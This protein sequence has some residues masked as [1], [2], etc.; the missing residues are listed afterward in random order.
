Q[1]DWSFFLNQ[2]FFARAKAASPQKELRDLGCRFSLTGPRDSHVLVGFVLPLSASTGLPSAITSRVRQRG[3]Y[4][5]ESCT[6]RARHC[7]IH[8][9]MTR[10]WSRAFYFG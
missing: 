2:N 7:A 4:T 5:I 8:P 6:K 10:R 9:N 3:K 1:A